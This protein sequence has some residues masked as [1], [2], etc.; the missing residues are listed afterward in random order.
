MFSKRFSIVAMLLGVLLVLGACSEDKKE[1]T[2]KSGEDFLILTGDTVSEQGGCVLA[3]RYSAGDKIVFRMNAYDS[4]TNEQ[5]KDA[6][7]K[8]HLSTGEELDMVYGTHGDEDFWVVAY[9][10]TEETPT[11]S[12]EYY[13]T[14]EAGDLKGEFR[15]FNVAPSLL[16]IVDLSEDGEAA[17]EPEKE[18]EEEV[19]LATVETDQNIDVY[20]KNFVFTG[21]NGEKVFYVKA[22]EEATLSLTSDEGLHGLAIEG[23]D[24]NIE[25]PNGKATF[26]PKEPGEYKMYCSVFCGAGHG[27]M[28]TKLVVVK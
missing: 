28:T 11:G 9:P 3:S 20:A 6:K 2:E 21:K 12:F 10:V 5:M 14:G 8:V 16:S 13:I 27:D 17:V 15:P 22:G 25:D 4:K 1:S 18:D 7:L 26:T 19:D 24:V 23:L